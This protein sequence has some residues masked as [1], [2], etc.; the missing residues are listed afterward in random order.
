MKEL[1]G[2]A[3]EKKLDTRGQK[4][5]EKKVEKAKKEIIEEDSREAT[6]RNKIKNRKLNRVNDELNLNY[7]NIISICINTYI[8]K[9]FS[10]FQ[11]YTIII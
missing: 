6:I 7:Y 2:A 8:P 4:A 10:S 9:F 11:I 5:A 1:K 3:K